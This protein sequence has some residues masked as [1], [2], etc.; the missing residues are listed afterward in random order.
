VVGRRHFAELQATARRH[1]ALPDE[2]ES[3]RPVAAHRAP[4]A[5][6]GARASGYAYDRRVAPQ[7]EPA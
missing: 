1:A 6:A 2:I 7:H 4:D 3:Q 5:G